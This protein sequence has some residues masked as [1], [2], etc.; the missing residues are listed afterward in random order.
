[1]SNWSTGILPVIGNARSLA[2]I[3]LYLNGCSS[4]RPVL[5][6]VRATSAISLSVPSLQ[7]SPLSEKIMLAS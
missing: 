7:L 6:A 5:L 2:T 1:M 3:S 4:Y